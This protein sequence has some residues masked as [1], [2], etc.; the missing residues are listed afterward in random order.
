MMSHS[1]DHSQTMPCGT[2]ILF[3]GGQFALLWWKCRYSSQ[4]GIS[5]HHPPLSPNFYSQCFPLPT[6][7]IVH[8]FNYWSMRFKI[9]WNVVLLNERLCDNFLLFNYTWPNLQCLLFSGPFCQLP[10]TR[11]NYFS[12]AKSGI[13]YCNEWP[14]ELSF[15]FL[16]ILPCASLIYLLLCSLSYFDLGFWSHFCTAT[17][18]SWKVKIK[19]I[20]ALSCSLCVFIHWVWFLGGSSWVWAIFNFSICVDQHDTTIWLELSRN[21]VAPK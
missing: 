11:L 5:L 3:D 18:N 21:A 15:L 8:V 10:F 19:E 20:V 17:L 4:K 7:N 14:Y 1:S 16:Y 9:G 12:C 13:K 2:I 6:A